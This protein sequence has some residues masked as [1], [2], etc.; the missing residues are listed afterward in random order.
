[1]FTE[2]ESEEREPSPPVRRAP[3]PVPPEFTESLTDQSP[4]EGDDLVLRCTVKGTPDP[5]VEWFIDGEVS[6]FS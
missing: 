4:L 3:S 2:K 6:C 5:R 1:M